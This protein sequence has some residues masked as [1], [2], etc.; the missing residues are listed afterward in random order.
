MD[1]QQKTIENFKASINPYVRMMLLKDVHK[2]EYISKPEYCHSDGYEDLK[3]DIIENGIKNPLLFIYNGG[4]IKLIEGYQR[5]KIASELGL[6]EVPVVAS[7]VTKDWKFID[8]Q[9]FVD[10]GMFNFYC[11]YKYDY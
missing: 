8:Q 1:T 2:P 6:T 5:I 10:L 11:K 3:K 4:T 7:K 9:A